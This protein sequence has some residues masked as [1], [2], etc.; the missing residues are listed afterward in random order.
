MK[1]T[2]PTDQPGVYAINDIRVID[3]DAIEATICLP[4]ETIIRKRIRLR[5]WWADE[6]QGTHSESGL[7]SKIRLEA[8]VA[9]RPLW[10]HSSSERIDRYGR[11]VATL[12]DGTRIVPAS[13]V[14]GDGQL[15]EQV[16]K[17]RRDAIARTARTVRG[18][19]YA[20]PDPQGL[21]S[22]PRDPDIAWP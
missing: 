3:G 19:C 14:L 11:I 5:G 12:L 9:S 2:S 22:L 1:N 18:Q 6:L 21:T 17:E 8:F 10:I 20:A 16:H 4:F 13:E 15:T 7:R